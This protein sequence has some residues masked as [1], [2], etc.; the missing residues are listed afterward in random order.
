[1]TTLIISAALAIVFIVSLIILISVLIKQFKYGG[2][3][4][5]IIGLITGGM[6]TFIWGWLKNKEFE[7][8]KVMILWT[9]FLLILASPIVVTNFTE[10]PIFNDA[11]TMVTAAIKDRSIDPIM[12]SL[13]RIQKR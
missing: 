2:I 11:E 3:L 13:E 5:G 8:T 7:M 4:H 6:W 1:M 10:V 12:Q 9:F